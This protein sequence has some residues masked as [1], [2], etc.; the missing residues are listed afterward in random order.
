M[1][2]FRFDRRP[3]Q[4]LMTAIGIHLRE[5][6]GFFTAETA[7]HNKLIAGIILAKHFPPPGSIVDSLVGRIHRT[8]LVYGFGSKRFQ[9]DC[10]VA[11]LRRRNTKVLTNLPTQRIG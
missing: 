5:P 10:E 3:I 7:G 4:L 8:L 2:L 6:L 11:L 1:P 9:E